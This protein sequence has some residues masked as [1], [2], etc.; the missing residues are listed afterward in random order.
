MRNFTRV[1]RAVPPRRVDAR[2]V[3]ER[4]DFEPRV[5]GDARQ[6]GRLRVVQ[7]L[8]PR[9]LGERLSGL[10]G[11]DEPRELVERDEVDDPRPTGC[12]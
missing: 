6:A 9:V 2:G 3:V 10:L 12:R 8:E 11:L 5:V 4:G 1:V 7:R